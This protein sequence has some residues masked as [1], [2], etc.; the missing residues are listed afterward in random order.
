MKE[1]A[2][3]WLIVF[4]RLAL[5][6]YLIAAG[7]AVLLSGAAPAAAAGQPAV[8]LPA[9]SGARVLFYAAPLLAAGAFAALGLFT[10]QA[11]LAAALL[12]LAVLIE[13][14]V[15]NPLHNTAEHLLP[16]FLLALGVLWVE[17]AGNRFSADA[18]LRPKAPAGAPEQGLVV[19]LL[20]LFIGAIFIAQGASDLFG[21]GGPLGFAEEVYVKPLAGSWMPA[22]LLWI[23]GALNPPTQLLG[24]ALLVLGLKTRWVA[25]ALAA[26]M[27][28]ILF[29]HVLIDPF[30]RGPGTHDYALA[31][32]LV[33]LLVLALSP[34][35]D[36]FGVDGLLGRRAVRLA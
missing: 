5:G 17:P 9:H 12:L 36:R 28:T 3:S 4:L 21:A 1:P 20:R 2:Y 33:I 7:L 27:M 34:R 26:F 16:L 30:D 14:L 31:N 32:L 29:G 11:A 6:I 18:L 19:L 22:P 24:G 25:A 8:W 15:T 23:A 10:R 13:W 35:G